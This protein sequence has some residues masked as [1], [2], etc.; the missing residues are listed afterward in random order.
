MD[1]HDMLRRLNLSHIS[2]TLAET[3]LQ[4]AKANPSHEAFL[5]KLA[6]PECAVS[7]RWKNMTGSFFRNELAQ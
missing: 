1:P 4:A 2:A 7:P 5:Y 6:A 3:V